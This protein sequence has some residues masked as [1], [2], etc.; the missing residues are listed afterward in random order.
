[1]RMLFIS[2]VVLSLLSSQTLKGLYFKSK[3]SNYQPISWQAYDQAIVLFGKVLEQKAL[4]TVEKEQ[5]RQL[6]LSFEVQEPNK[7]VI[8]SSHGGGFYIIN[9]AASKSGM[10]SIPHRF[11]DRY[12]G[13]IGYDLMQEEGYRAVAL[14]TVHRK[15]QDMA[16]TEQTLFGA[17]HIAFA[18]LYPSEAI[19][20]LHGFNGAKRQP[21]IQ[22]DTIVSAT[23]RQSTPKAK[24]LHSCLKAAGYQSRL[25]GSDVF[26]LGGTTNVQAKE[27]KRVGFENFIHIEIN[28]ALRERLRKSREERQKFGRCLP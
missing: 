9:F 24:S 12:T 4:N 3:V 10:L 21:P 5:W 16:H 14:S 7:V 19:Y 6:G 18:S 20:Q 11:Y 8:G 1:M 26:E 28:V 2:M 23:K 27:L 13:Q 15:I 25:Y 17:F 22:A